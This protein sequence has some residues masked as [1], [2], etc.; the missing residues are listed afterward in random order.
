[1][2]ANQIPAK[3][4][5]PFGN[6][7][8]S[9][10]IRAIPAASQIGLVPGAASLADGFP[11]LTGVALAS[12]GYP[13]SMQDF[14]GVLNL[15]TAWDQWTAAAGIAP[16]DA[17]FSAQ[18]GGYPNGAVVYT[19]SATVLGRI[20]V[21]IAD[22]NTTNPDSGGAN[23]VP[24]VL[25]VDLS[26][27]LAGLKV[28]GHNRV[29]FGVGTTAWVVP[30]GV[31]AVFARV[32]GAGGGGGGALN[33]SC[34]ATGG[35]AGGYAEG[36][37][38][39]TPG[40]TISVVVGAGGAGGTAGGGN[41]AAGGTSSFTSGISC[42]GG[43]AGQGASSGINNSA[44]SGG[45]AF[46][47]DFRLTGSGASTGFQVGGSLYTGGTGGGGYGF[48]VSPITV[49]A[50]GGGGAGF[51]GGGGGASGN[52]AGGSGSPGLVTIEY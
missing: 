26:A 21:S 16:Y 4:P 24:I 20:W 34:A 14:N 41:G 23:W 48:Q 46:G 50:P 10:Y 15:A 11:P 19:A 39:V 13:P 32:Y 35:G 17:A 18:I 33:S 29:S 25:P 40:S 3:F 22:N 9:G 5:V 45:S 37:I 12:G 47:G 52:Y 8:G 1:M 7:A 42:T 27:L 36:F 51:A 30:A 49:G 31:T 6:N 44:V 38:A 43:G 2:R 28:T